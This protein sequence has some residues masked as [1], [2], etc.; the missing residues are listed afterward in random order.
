MKIKTTDGRNKH[1]KR[2]DDGKKGEYILPGKS[3]SRT[4]RSPSS[5]LIPIKILISISDRQ[6]SINERTQ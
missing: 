6:F 1:E 4:A 5:L 2:G 3:I